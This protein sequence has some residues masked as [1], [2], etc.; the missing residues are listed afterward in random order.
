MSVDSKTVRRVA[1]L[2]RL[3]LPEAD[4][5]GLAAELNKILGWIDQLQA[6]DTEGVEPLAVVVPTRAPWRA[7]EVTD[8]DIRDA[9]LANAPASAHGFFVVPKVIE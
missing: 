3:Q 9:V 1:K 4:V 2:A 5:A 7:D 6:V 8:G